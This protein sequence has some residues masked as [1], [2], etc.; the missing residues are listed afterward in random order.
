MVLSGVLI[1]VRLLARQKANMKG[2]SPGMALAGRLSNPKVP[3][4]ASNKAKNARHVSAGGSAKVGRAKANASKD[5]MDV[6][7]PVTGKSKSANEKPAKKTQE[8]LD[9]EMRTWDRQRRFAA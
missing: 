6:D 3:T 7:R 5:A 2:K 1:P 8:Q 9:E 4:M